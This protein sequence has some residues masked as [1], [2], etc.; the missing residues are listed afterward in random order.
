MTVTSIEW[1]DFTWNPVRGCSRIS[2]GCANCYAEKMAARF[3]DPGM[4]AHGFA[5][6]TPAGARWTGKVE[7][8]PEKLAEPLSWRKPRR[9][10]VNS[11]SDLF[12]EALPFEHIAAVF[13]VMAATP[14]VTYQI[15]TKRAER[16]A[17]FFR[18]LPQQLPSCG[19]RGSTRGAAW[20]TWNVLQGAHEKVFSPWEVGAVA[21]PLPNVWL[22]VSVENQEAADQ[23]IPHLLATPAAVRFLSME[24]LLGPVDLNKISWG[25]AGLIYGVLRDEAETD[26]W[27]YW[28]K[29]DGGI[30]WV[31]V[32]GESGNGPGIRPMH[33][34]W[35]RSLRDQCVAAGVPY[36]FKQ[37]GTWAAIDQ[38]WEQD[39]PS[40]LNEKRERWLNLAGGH[41]FHGEEVW[42]M[43]RAGKKGAGR[44]LDGREWNEMPEVPHA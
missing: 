2:P 34:D 27:R 25:P 36:F 43:R 23:R 16:M 9:V 14:H 18:W 12:H 38:P 22:G 11:M 8:I 26:D 35:A 7:L 28:A 44:L 3:S 4:Y 41:G 21:W 42:R 31:I 37:W 6:R 24:P 17:E 10:F 39:S 1:T 20:Y 40:R 29:R 30:S 13:G 15:L 5:E 33:P 32:G 19:E